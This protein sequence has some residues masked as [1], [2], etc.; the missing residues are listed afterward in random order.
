MSYE[1]GPANLP[2]ASESV[3]KPRFQQPGIYQCLVVASFLIGLTLSYIVWGPRPQPVAAGAKANAA[4]AVTRQ[5]AVGAVS[6][7]TSAEVANGLDLVA[8]EQQV[9]PRAGYQLPVSYGDLGPRLLKSGAINYD[10]FT[11]VY[12]Q[13]GD[14]LTAAEV[15]VLQRGA[16]DPITITA[17]N[18]HFLLNFF[19]AVGLVNNNKILTEGPMVQNSGGQIERFAST[20]G[21]TLGSKPVKDLYAS[22]ELIPLTEEQQKRVEE[23]ASAVYRPCCG[24]STLFPDCNHGMAMLGLLELMAARDASIDQ[25]FTAAKYVNAYWFP[26]QAMEM[27]AYLRASQGIDFVRADPRMVTGSEYSSGAGAQQVHAALQGRG[28]LPKTPDGGGSCGS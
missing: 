20:G 6:T 7:T 12:K 16:D 13:A 27:A 10:A 19:W 11:A 14:P 28:L 8:L 22:V 17:E 5:A 2:V 4:V 3:Q 18:A 25:M 9:N 1:S 24:N 23:V 21:W 26:Q 15:D